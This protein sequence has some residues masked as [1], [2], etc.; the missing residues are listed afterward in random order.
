MSD[1]WYQTCQLLTYLEQP[2]LA[3]SLGDD[4]YQQ[5]I[6]LTLTFCIDPAELTLLVQ[7]VACYALLERLHWRQLDWSCC[8]QTDIN[9]TACTETMGITMWAK[10]ASAWVYAIHMTMCRRNKPSILTNSHSLE[11]IDPDTAA[12]YQFNPTVSY[13]WSVMCWKAQAIMC[14]KIDLISLHY[15]H[16]QLTWTVSGSHDKNLT[17]T[18]QSIHLGKQLINDSHTGSRLQE[19]RK[20]TNL[21]L[22]RQMTLWITATQ[23]HYAASKCANILESEYCNVSWYSEAQLACRVAK[24][25][26]EKRDLRIFRN[27]FFCTSRVAFVLS[28]FPIHSSADPQSFTMLTFFCKMFF[29]PHAPVQGILKIYGTVTPQKTKRSTTQ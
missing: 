25:K 8:I 7:Y 22:C 15:Q 13:S 28:T 17:S 24:K 4:R 14:W 29:V 9:G 18:F 16:L 1:Q 19:K 20:N 23:P 3:H 5:P 2:V 26:K 6:L 11:F 12:E 21:N 10:T 27:I